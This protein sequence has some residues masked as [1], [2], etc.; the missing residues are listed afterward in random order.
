MQMTAQG[1]RMIGSGS[2]DAGGSKAPGGAVG[3][4]GLIATR[5]PAGLIISGVSKYRGEKTGSSKVEG[6]ARQTAGEI[7]NV[8]EERFKEQGWITGR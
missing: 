2:S 7:A 5:N 8:L 3:V 4:V 6:R 1:L